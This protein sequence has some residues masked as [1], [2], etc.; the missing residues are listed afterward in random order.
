MQLMLVQTCTLY[1]P[2]LGAQHG[3]VAEDAADFEVEE[4]ERWA[5][6][7]ITSET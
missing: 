2:G 5:I 4:V 7:W 3:V 6:S 1:L